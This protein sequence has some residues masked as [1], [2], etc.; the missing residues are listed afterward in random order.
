[1]IEKKVY[2]SIENIIKAALA[3][4]IKT[5]DITSL[6]IIDE[7]LASNF[8]IR[9]RED[10]ILAGSKLIEL[11][12]AQL[13]PNI[14]IELYYKDGDFVKE[15]SIIA[16]GRGKMRAVLT[17]ERVMLNLL[18]HLCGIASL[19]E[20]FVKLVKH[21]KAKIRDTRKTLP[22]L[23]ELQKYAVRMGG[24]EN[25]R[26]SLDE[27][28]L[29]KDNHIAMVGS[30]IQAFEKAKAAYPDKIVEIECDTI[31]QVKEALLTNCDA[32]LLD[33]MSIE[34]LK[35][36]VKLIDGKI[37]TEASG[38]V[39][40]ENVK[41]IAETGVDYIAVG[42]LTHSVKSKDIGLDILLTPQA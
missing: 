39:T 38:G 36:A 21:T 13:D 5:G 37:K 34:M 29:I 27:M 33:N 4:D 17:A 28:I 31:S 24:G 30:V 25:H 26:F 42:S 12:F 7:D 6:A 1:M 32:I 8:V 16:K 41:A 14:Q 20:E 40:L 23:R 22:L 11:S 3:E 18:Q 19:T 35:E 10:L 2:M 9:N 15:A